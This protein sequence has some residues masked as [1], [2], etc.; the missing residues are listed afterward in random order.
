M[1]QIQLHSLVIILFLMSGA[2]HHQAEAQTSPAGTHRFEFR[3]EPLDRALFVISARTG[4]EFIYEPQITRGVIVNGI[5]Q[6]SSLGVILDEL[7]TPTGLEARRIRTGMYVV[8]HA[9]RRSLPGRMLPTE[10]ADL[11]ARS[12]LQPYRKTEMIGA[13]RTLTVSE[14]ILRIVIP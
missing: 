6:D 10:G 8:R 5:Y 14:I 2:V 13:D 3:N 12:R 1:R 11:L 9:M 7:L 4:A